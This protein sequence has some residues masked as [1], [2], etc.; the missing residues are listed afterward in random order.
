MQHMHPEARLPAAM[1]GTVHVEGRSEPHA[2]VLGTHTLPTPLPFQHARAS[3][4]RQALQR[5]CKLYTL[6]GI[7][8]VKLTSPS[9]VRSA[10]SQ[11]AS[12]SWPPCSSRPSA[13]PL[14]W[15][16]T[17]ATCVSVPRAA[18]AT[19]YPR[20]FLEDSGAL[21]QRHLLQGR[22]SLVQAKKACSTQGTFSDA[23]RAERC[24]PSACRHSV[25]GCVCTVCE[26]V[27]SSV[28]QCSPGRH[29]T[30][31][32]ASTFAG[33]GVVGGW[34]A[35]ASICAC[36]GGVAACAWLCRACTSISSARIL[37]ACSST[38]RRSATGSIEVSHVSSA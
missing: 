24:Q 38:C 12:R 10:C 5:A 11:P 35:G 20:P 14:T 33:L 3:H 31:H 26:D 18:F 23:G 6:L 37:T 13:A 15:Y 32:S 9:G 21:Y 28:K 17:G 27:L 8:H 19:S 36:L 22:E 25:S 34:L 2:C 1:R 29:V 30:Q 4:I 7:M 16:H